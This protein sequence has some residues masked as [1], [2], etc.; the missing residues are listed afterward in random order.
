LRA[1]VGD[2]GQEDKEEDWVGARHV[3]G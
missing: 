1:G 2:E 3:H